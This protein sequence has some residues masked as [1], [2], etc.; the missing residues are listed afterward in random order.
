MVKGCNFLV[1]GMEYDVCIFVVKGM[2]VMKT[3]KVCIFN[4]MKGLEGCVYRV[5]GM[6]VMKK[7]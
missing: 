7:K 4:G 2:K 1:K 6:K 3:K 5:K